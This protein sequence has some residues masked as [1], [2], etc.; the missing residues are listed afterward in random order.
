MPPSPYDSRDFVR[1]VM[2]MA[3]LGTIPVVGPFLPEMQQTVVEAIF[4]AKASLLPQRKEW[5]TFL[6]D[7]NGGYID[8]LNGIRAAMVESGMK[9]RG[10]VQSKARSAGFML[11][12]YCNWRVALSNSELLF[13]Y[14][15]A[16]L[17]NDELSSIVEDHEYVIKYH[18]QRLDQMVSDIQARTGLSKETLHDLAKYQ[19]DILAERAL[20][21]NL[22]DEVITSVPK[23]EKPPA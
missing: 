11:L 12:Q 13:H 4:V 8:M 18:K 7:S 22:L 5:V 20:E 9:F 15:G 6:I 23:S 10:S 17:W 3:K 1:S 16:G 19:R 2:E 21:M 14:G